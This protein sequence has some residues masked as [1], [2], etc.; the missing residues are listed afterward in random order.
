MIEKILKIYRGLDYIDDRLYAVVDS[1]YTFFK[2]INKVIKKYSKK[3]YYKDELNKLKKMYSYKVNEYT[4]DTFREHIESDDFSEYYTKIFSYFVY[5][6]ML[7]SVYD[8]EVLEKMR[9][10]ILSTMVIRFILLYYRALGFTIDEN[11]F[12]EISHL[13]SKEIEHNESNMKK[14]YAKIRKLKLLNDNFIDIIS[15]VK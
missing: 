6:H 10:S 3:E 8:F 2:L 15:K 1:A 7:T 9:F 5:K 11:L 13:Y 14:L 12:I 4:L